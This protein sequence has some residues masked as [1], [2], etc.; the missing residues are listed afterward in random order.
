MTIRYQPSKVLARM[1]SK[2]NVEKLLTKKL[3]VNRA[4][5]NSIANSGIVGKDA[6][7]EIA[8][9]VLKDYR[10]RADDLVAKG[11]TKAEATR[12]LTDDPAQLVQRVQNATVD[13]ITE[14][15]KENYEGE[16]YTWLP[17]TAKHRRKEHVLKYGKTFQLG[18]GEAPGDK[19][20]CRCGM[21][22]HTP[23]N[24]LNL[25]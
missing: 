7:E 24:R 21:E 2:K 13:A 10:S 19:P 12:E 9:G 15:V 17:S 18:K 25:E 4:A 23:E 22:I 1:A 6:L 14:R 3:T 11:A 5:L 8:L 20:G 16:F